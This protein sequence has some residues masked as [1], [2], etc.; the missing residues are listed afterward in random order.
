MYII[1]YVQNKFYF[2]RDGGGMGVAYL[3][4]DFIYEYF[5]YVLRE[6]IQHSKPSTLSL[7]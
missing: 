4:L 5:M 1:K 6:I 7:S 2:K 3:T